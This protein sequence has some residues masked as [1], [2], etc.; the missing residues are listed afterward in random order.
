MKQTYMILDHKNKYKPYWELNGLSVKTLIISSMVYVI[1]WSLI[2]YKKLL[3]LKSVLIGI[4]S[5]III[6]GVYIFM[7]YNFNFV[8]IDYKTNKW[9][10]A[11]TPTYDLISDLCKIDSDIKLD[12]SK[13][14]VFITEEYLKKL[15]NKTDVF[16]LYDNI[17]NKKTNKFDNSKM[18]YFNSNAMTF[19]GYCLIVILFSLFSILYNNHKSLFFN[20]FLI[21]LYTILL[22]IPILFVS[23]N[24]YTSSALLINND[25]RNQIL[26]MAVSL[27]IGILS[28]L[29]SYY[30]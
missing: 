2:Y 26:F 14:G 23:M 30:N 10:Q 13:Q 8:M 16:S 27:T 24:Y 20:L 6:N 12:K 5:L 17:N 11:N 22:A 4:L 3:Q 19:Q 28:E 21:F 25:I 29:L 7:Y 1:L 9:I 18:M 15:K